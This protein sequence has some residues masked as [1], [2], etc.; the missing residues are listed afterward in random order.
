MCLLPLES[1]PSAPSV[2]NLLLETSTE[3]FHCLNFFSSN[4]LKTSPVNSSLTCPTT[5]RT[6]TDSKENSSSS[7]SYAQALMQAP[8][9]PIQILTPMFYSWVS[10]RFWSEPHDEKY[11]HNVLEKF[12]TAHVQSD[13]FNCRLL[14]SIFGLRMQ[15]LHSTHLVLSRFCQRHDLALR[16]LKFHGIPNLS[17][18]MELMHPQRC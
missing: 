5:K 8:R 2:S 7:K 16:P 13:M 12:V 17:L 11:Y 1:A 6:T 18:E 3:K 9:L 15:H 10:T 4:L 14:D